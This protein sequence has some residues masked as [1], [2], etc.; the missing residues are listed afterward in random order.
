MLI[1]GSAE[2]DRWRSVR[3]VSRSFQPRSLV[4][5]ALPEEWL[6]VLSHQTCTGDSSVSLPTKSLRVYP[7]SFCVSESTYLYLFTSIPTFPGRVAHRSVLH[8]TGFG[9]AGSRGS[10]GSRL[11]PVKHCTDIQHVSNKDVL[12][13]KWCQKHLFQ[14]VYKYLCNSTFLSKPWDKFTSWWSLHSSKK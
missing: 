2:A 12:L 3:N 14:T 5:R 7:P 4:Q 8:V 11:C 6:S 1:Q 10:A 9:W 13:P